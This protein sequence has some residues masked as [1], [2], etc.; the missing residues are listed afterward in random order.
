MCVS[1]SPAIAPNKRCTVQYLREEEGRQYHQS[2]ILSGQGVGIG[3]AEV[4]HRAVAVQ[5]LVR[6]RSTTVNQSLQ[7]L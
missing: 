5:S 3:H 2:K 7:Q 4:D 6:Q 1:C